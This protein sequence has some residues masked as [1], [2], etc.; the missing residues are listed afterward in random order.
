MTIFDVHI[1][2]KVIY[3]IISILVAYILILVESIIINN[4]IN[5]NKTKSKHLRRSQNTVLEL[6]K[7]IIKVVIIM[8]T[9]ISILKIFGVDTTA[10]VTS[11][12][13]ISVVIGLAFQDIL[14]DYLVGITIILESQFALGEIVE[15]D[16]FKGEVVSLGLKTTRI[17]ALTGEVKIISNRNISQVIN[18]S[19]DKSLA[20]IKVSVSYEDDINKVE[21]V[22]T[23]L[24]KKLEKNIDEITDKIQIDGID[25][26]ADS[27]IVFRLSTR[28]RNRDIPI[29][30][31]KVYK[32]VKLAFDE[33]NIKI[34]YPQVEVHHDK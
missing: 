11:I 17:K 33:N 2:E 1:P 24:S 29:I 21:E 32:E 12:G 22:L 10:L 28:A 5:N 3:P 4:I 9:L 6:I 34:P 15:I 30:K 19:L 18:Y 31:R 23:K 13:A 8:V 26:L 25:E 20:I 27:S 7:K 14:K 16:G